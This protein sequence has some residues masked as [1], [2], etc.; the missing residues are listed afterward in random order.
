MSHTRVK[1]KYEEEGPYA[2][3]TEE[4]LYC[5]H[6]HTCDVVTFYDGDGNHLL[7]INEFSSNNLWTAIEKLMYYH[8]HLEQGIG[9]F[10]NKSGIEYW[11]AEDKEK[12][13]R[14]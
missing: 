12:I 10:D 13:N 5:H 9:S 8:R 14:K 6:N 7:S 3:T 2:S 1:V 4:T 11:S